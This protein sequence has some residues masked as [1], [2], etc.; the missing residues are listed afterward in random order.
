MAGVKFSVNRE[1]VREQAGVLLGEL[2]AST[3][4]PLEGLTVIESLYSLL[5]L[6]GMDACNGDQAMIEQARALALRSLDRMQS[7]CLAYPARVED[8]S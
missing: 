5:L 6:R 3:L 7:R 2:E 1:A 4:S 8:R